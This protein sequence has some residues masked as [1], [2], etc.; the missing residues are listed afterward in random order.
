MGFLKTI[1]LMFYVNFKGRCPFRFY[2]KYTLSFFKIQKYNSSGNLV[3]TIENEVSIN[4]EYTFINYPLRN[5]IRGITC[6]NTYLYVSMEHTPIIRFNRNTLVLDYNFNL[7]GV[8]ASE[9]ILYKNNFMYILN[10]EYQICKYQ[11]TSTNGTLISTLHSGISCEQFGIDN[12]GKVYLSDEDDHIC[13]YQS[14]MTNIFSSIASLQTENIFIGPFNKIYVA[15]DEGCISVYDPSISNTYTTYYD[16]TENG[17]YE[18]Q[19]Y[20]YDYSYR[21]LLYMNNVY[22]YE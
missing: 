17:E 4:D 1:E 13:I 11:L 19:V 7:T 8:N 9:Y 21:I 22:V 16:A 3:G 2:N 15:D 18:I 14:D 20:F 5:Y 10:D 6:D 12:S